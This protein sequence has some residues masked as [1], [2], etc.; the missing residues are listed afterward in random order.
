MV[1]LVGQSLA[2][3][4]IVAKLGEG[5]MGIVYKATDEKLRRS[6]ALKVLPDSFAQDED[7]RRRFLREARSAAAV[8]HANIATVHEV[9]EADGHVFIAMELVEGE[10][11]RARLEKGL[12][13]AESVRV[14]KEIARGVA[15]A[16][17]KGIVHRDLKPEN[18][19][20]T[21]HDEVKILDFGL[22]KLREEQA[23]TASALE[24]QDTA[25]QLTR[26][27][28]LLGTPGYM[29]PEQARGQ[30]VDARTDVF[31][32]GVVLY[33]M[34]TAE[35]PF[36]GETTQDVLTAVMRDTP[37]RAS[38]KNPLVSVELDRVV[39]RCLEK[40]RD[41]RYANAQELLDPLEGVKVYADGAVSRRSRPP[42]NEIATRIDAGA[43]VM[44]NPLA[45]TRSR[46]LPLMV[47]L[48][49][50]V[51]L[52]VLL[53]VSLR[54]TPAALSAAASA[55]PGNVDLP[56]SPI[57]DAQRLLEEAM[58]SFH[59]GT[60]QA[61]PLLESAVKADPSFGGAFLRLI[62]MI[63]KSTLEG[64]RQL[65]E[66]RR[67]LVVLEPS[68]SAR[69]RALYSIVDAM[70]MSNPDTAAIAAK[71][72]A[73]L[74]RYPNDG[75]AWTVRFDVTPTNVLDV[76]DRALVVDDTFVP[77]L[78]RKVSILEEARRYDEADEVVARC[79][80]LSPRAVECLGRRAT[81]LSTI[82]K[83]AEAEQDVR[84][85]QELQPDSRAARELLAALL[86]A[87]NRPVEAVREA[88]D[89][90]NAVSAD[91]PIANMPAML[92]E[93]AIP[94]LVSD[95]SEVVRI[96]EEQAR[97][98]R[99]SKDERA[100]FAPA[101]T[102]ILAYNEMGELVAAGRVAASYLA[103][104]AAWNNLSP[105]METFM[106]AAAARGGQLPVTAADA[107]IAAA[108]QAAVARHDPPIEAWLTIYAWSTE[109]PR[110]A[111]IAV[112]ALDELDAALPP[113]ELLGRKLTCAVS[114][115]SVG[116]GAS[117]A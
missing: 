69:D 64:T 58:R 85:W 3:F 87:Q 91:V 73:Y 96:G 55:S 34:V 16:H 14:A 74:A 76:V 48:L 29:S 35:R 117:P 110:E 32:F 65:A 33:E 60:G 108:F 21:S 1:D 13:V 39:E 81:R 43:S 10:T 36:V 86:A 2:H 92:D 82:G 67:R 47:A 56:H 4:R 98:V 11:L 12:S 89:E 52:G 57:P 40:L 22:A 15:R 19:M 45:P 105:S 77:A 80:A 49:V 90:V 8:T 25:T 115:G 24:E 102:M 44:S 88:L 42:P 71:L 38:E 27:G 72:D 6:V 78:A 61:V 9:G 68:L 26:E 113:Q 107:R 99:A 7:R 53:K 66:Y 83:C 104:R 106:F 93:A 18:V 20:I 114:R 31:A 28:K 103:R 101:A 41:A 37:K 23:A 94:M 116:P 84:R 62:V 111:R 70:H 50:L 17:E 100:Q 63:D 75:A 51:G 97:R 46:F 5:G 109:T 59:D 54:D 30:E 112:A 95:F 79:L